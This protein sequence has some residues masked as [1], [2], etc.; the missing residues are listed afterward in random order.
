MILKKKTRVKQ[1]RT[2]KQIKKHGNLILL[3][4]LR[5][6]CFPIQCLDQLKTKTTTKQDNGSKTEQRD[7]LKPQIDDLSNCVKKSKLSGYVFQ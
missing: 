6:A 5:V 1:T 4:L 3:C 7:K 2:Y